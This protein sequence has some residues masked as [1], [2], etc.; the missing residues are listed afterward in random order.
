MKITLERQIY[1]A[2]IFAMILLSVLGFFAYRSINS[3]N[4]AIRWEKQTQGVLSQL[5][6][7]LAL[8]V[9]AETGG[10]GFVITGNESFLEPYTQTKLKIDGILAE[11]RGMLTDNPSQKQTLAILE[12]VI[13]KKLFFIK[14]TVELRRDQ[15]FSAALEQINT[16]QGKFLMEEIRRLVKEMK[17]KEKVLLQQRIWRSARFTKCPRRRVIGV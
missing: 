15:S 2:F 10:R 9:D 8:I 1:L 12:D 17:D 4:E 16:G 7:T 5:D 13:N 6:E 3:L 11:L 14:Q